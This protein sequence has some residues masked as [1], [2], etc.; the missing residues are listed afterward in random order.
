MQYP[1][2]K[3]SVMTWQSENFNIDPYISI[4][5]SELEFI[6]GVANHWKETETGGELFGLLTHA[7]R[8]VIMLATPPGPKAIHETAHFR[9]CV[10]FIRQAESYL[11][12]GFGL[13]YMGNFHS[14]HSL[15]IKGLSS[16]DILG[17]HTIAG[18]NGYCR[19]CQ[20]VTTFEEI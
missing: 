18:K 1:K 8:P 17:T 4:M 5:Q 11:K 15:S 3:V 9:Q 13:Q 14:H 20:I 6:A 10:T 16:G 7:G 2:G 19:L 12:D